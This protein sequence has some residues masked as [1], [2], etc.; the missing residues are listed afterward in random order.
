MQ[1]ITNSQNKLPPPATPPPPTPKN[2]K[3]VREIEYPSG[4]AHIIKSLSEPDS[5]PKPA[6]KQK[7][8]AVKVISTSAAAAHK[9]T[10]I[11]P[12]PMEQLVVNIPPRSSLEEYQK[13][14]D[15]CK[16]AFRSYLEEYSRI[17]MTGTA[18][19]EY[20]RQYPA[21]TLRENRLKNQ[22]NNLIQVI[23]E[24]TAHY[25]KLNLEPGTF[26]DTTHST[27]H[28]LTVWH[29]FIGSLLS[30]EEPSQLIKNSAFK[31]LWGKP[32]E[33]E[34]ENSI[35]KAYRSYNRLGK[36]ILI[37][38][39]I[40]TTF[41]HFFW[42]KEFL[43]WNERIV[44]KELESLL[45]SFYG[46][47]YFTFTIDTFREN[48]FDRY[49]LHRYNWT[50]LRMLLCMIYREP[51]VVT[52]LPF[53]EKPEF[54]QEPVLHFA[55]TN[56]QDSFVPLELLVALNLVKIQRSS[57]TSHF[58][59]TLPHTIGTLLLTFHLCKYLQLREKNP[60][61]AIEELLSVITDLRSIGVDCQCVEMMHIYKNRILED[62]AKLNPNDPDPLRLN[63]GSGHFSF[64]LNFELYKERCKRLQDE[65]RPPIATLKNPNPS[66]YVKSGRLL[67]NLEEIVVAAYR[68]R[69]EA[70][71]FF[72]THRREELPARRLSFQQ[73]A[74][75]LLELTKGEEL[76]TV[77]QHYV[78][79]ARLPESLP[80]YN[81]A[82]PIIGQETP[83]HVSFEA[84][85][86]DF[87]SFEM[88]FVA[89]FLPIEL[90]GNIYFADLNTH[91]INRI[92]DIASKAVSLYI[93]VNQ[94]PRY[95]LLHQKGRLLVTF[96]D[97]QQMELTLSFV[98]FLQW[99]NIR[100]YICLARVL[101]TLANEDRAKQLIA[102]HAPTL[103]VIRKW[104]SLSIEWHEKLIKNFPGLWT[105]EIFTKAFSNLISIYGIDSPYI[106]DTILK[107]P[108][109]PAFN[110]LMR[111]YATPRVDRPNTA[112]VLPNTADV[113][114]VQPPTGSQSLVSSS[115]GPDF[116]YEEFFGRIF[117]QDSMAQ[118][119]ETPPQ[120]AEKPSEPPP[121]QVE[122]PS[123][124]PPTKPN[125][126]AVSTIPSEP[127]VP[128]IQP[129]QEGENEIVLSGFIRNADSAALPDQTREQTREL[130][131]LMEKAGITGLPEIANFCCL[132][133]GLQAL[134]SY[135]D[136]A[137]MLEGPEVAD[138]EYREIKPTIRMLLQHIRNRD[139]A[140]AYAASISLKER[141]LQ[142][143]TFQEKEGTIGGNQKDAQEIMSVIL[144]ACGHT[145]R[146]RFTR[147]GTHQG[148][149]LILSTREQQG[150]ILPIE[151]G[152]RKKGPQMLEDA[153]PL[154]DLIKLSLNEIV[155]E[156]ANYEIN[157]KSITFK[158]HTCRRVLIEP[159]PRLLVL[160]VKRFYNENK[161]LA[162]R[163]EDISV[164]KNGI[165]DLTKYFDPSLLSNTQALRYQIVGTVNHMGTLAGGHYAAHSLREGVW[166]KVSDNAYIEQV[167]PSW[168][169]KQ[170]FIF[171]CSKVD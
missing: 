6:Q 66:E 132:N 30:I 168:V 88:K 133:A 123:E 21:L 55:T 11:V 43:S 27:F 146:E 153:V 32:I 23:K 161:R 16:E 25:A 59:P 96:T 56:E 159:I 78:A 116:N 110:A 109:F 134:M 107:V 57:M 142:M 150:P 22:Y 31:R 156:P 97:E 7:L 95:K 121:Q 85:H 19:T 53:D 92:V 171:V 90:L 165:L 70:L 72:A 3:R 148:K 98:E 76:S 112:V 71:L 144:N 80:K 83:Q 102:K 63:Q 48:H 170:A 120:P 26:L 17:Y 117:A 164:P 73:A 79:I 65:P 58:H 103:F 4:I 111:H 91:L 147:I 14:I 129:Q 140:A 82:L 139:T 69:Q 36:S 119:S 24:R 115:S 12:P 104:F 47:S 105:P 54:L 158:E 160:F 94:T 42:N 1:N 44:Y 18:E 124:P 89:D 87:P 5:Q 108:Q 39:V 93:P 35:L 163:I 62:C 152:P 38:D 137:Q 127:A 28:L 45:K 75:T 68:L 143:K 138:P 37:P 86:P 126:Q 157:Y 167:A 60:A 122:K 155:T 136:F 100:N 74:K 49:T 149:T 151:F 145:F 135:K 40:M 8:S 162:K 169:F 99:A 81:F 10:P 29:T 15:D 20:S 118:L 131:P 106:K 52:E 101:H 84:D 2:G 61:K 34:T 130:A 67:K 33:F 166:Y 41:A 141:L 13:C 154:M 114:I 77:Y 128:A 125:E 64:Q 9:L 50:S 51:W 46:H 113:T